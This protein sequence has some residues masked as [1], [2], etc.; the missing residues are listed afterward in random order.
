MHVA[1]LEL[2]AHVISLLAFYR[3]CPNLDFIGCFSLSDF[4]VKGPYSE[5]SILLKSPIKG[6]LLSR[7]NVYLKS[8]QAGFSGDACNGISDIDVSNFSSIDVKDDVRGIDTSKH[9]CCAGLIRSGVAVFKLPCW[10]KLHSIMM[11][12]PAG[13]QRCFHHDGNRLTS[14]LKR[15]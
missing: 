3:S 15:P 8:E 14:L 6:T 13:W 12:V 4:L 2:P 11:S 9:S 7:Y 5:P 10:L 1:S